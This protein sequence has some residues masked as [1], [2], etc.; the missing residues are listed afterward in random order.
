MWKGVSL[1]GLFTETDGTLKILG[2]CF[3]PNLLLEK[4]WL[5]VRE[6]AD[7]AV[8][9]WSTRKLYLKGS[10]EGFVFQIYQNLLYRPLGTSTPVR[11][12]NFVDSSTLSPL[13]V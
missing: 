11:Q 8:R 13:V 3:G 2:I 6:K 10:T 7:V 4:N 12:A 9:L 5:E 1:T